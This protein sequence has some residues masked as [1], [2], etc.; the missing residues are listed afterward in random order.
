M[1]L[2]Q[3][4][5]RAAWARGGRTGTRLERWL[6]ARTPLPP[7]GERRI[8]IG[9]GFS[10]RP[11]YLHVDAVPGLP[12]LDLV[13]RGD[14]LP[15][16]DDWADEILAVHMIE[17]VPAAQLPHVLR[18]WRRILRPGGRLVLHTPNGTALARAWLEGGARVRWPVIAALYGYNRAP[19]DAS[20]AEA[21][22]SEP[23]HRLL[24]D[25]DLATEELE[26]AGFVDVHDVSG[27]DPAC[28]HTR[29]WADWVPGL[30]LEVAAVVPQDARRQT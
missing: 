24:L 13:A 5:R 27:A 6:A 9:S 22:G 25:L 11:G 17:H 16:P 26:R 12:D 1:D 3:R 29:D 8:E 14:R 19:W 30:C 18:S 20:S 10:P 28:H 21:L 23:D 15:L 2:D 7:P 4:L